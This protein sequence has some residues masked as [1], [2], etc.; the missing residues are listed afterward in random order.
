MNKLKIL[1]TL[2]F[3]F[4]LMFNIVN[5]QSSG[6]EEQVLA[7]QSQPEQ[8][9]IT[10]EQEKSPIIPFLIILAMALFLK[11]IGGSRK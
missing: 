1:T 11:N 2:S 3:A 10:A 4:L 9:T 5:A 8:Q 7:F 6:N